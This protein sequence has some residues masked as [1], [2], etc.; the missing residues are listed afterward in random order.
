MNVTEYMQEHTKVRAMRNTDLAKEL[1]IKPGGVAWESW[2]EIETHLD[3]DSCIKRVFDLRVAA[4]LK[5]D[6][7]EPKQLAFNFGGK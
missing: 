4:R 7:N 2:D 6:I 3:R 1:G 5:A